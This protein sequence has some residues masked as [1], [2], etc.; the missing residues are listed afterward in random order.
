ML[1]AGSLMVPSAYAFEMTDVLRSPTEGETLTV[2]GVVTAVSNRS[3]VLTDKGGSIYVYTSALLPVERFQIGR[4]VEMTKEVKKY[5]NAYEFDSLSEIYSYQIQDVTYAEPVKLDA[6][7]A[8]EWIAS[9]ELVRPTYVTVTGV[10]KLDGIYV[11]VILDGTDQVEC[12]ILFPTEEEKTLLKEGER[13]EFEGYYVYSSVGK[14]INICATSIDGIR[15]NVYNSLLGSEITSPLA[16]SEYTSSIS[17][18]TSEGGS[19]LQ[20]VGGPLATAVVLDGDAKVLQGLFAILTGVGPGVSGVEVVDCDY[21]EISFDPASMTVSV[22]SAVKDARLMV[23]DFAGAM[24]MA[25]AIPADGAD[26]DLGNLPS[27][28]YIAAITSNNKI[29]KTLK[30]IVK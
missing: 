17:M 16:V 8:K 30:F 1:V 19:V 21:G 10:T 24:V 5:C 25:E 7:L 22:N 14:Y 4:Q 18:V 9:E 3:F 26:F 6:A 13:Q 23:V 15:T 29:Y 20:E 28:A 2:R 11:D 12:A 27:G